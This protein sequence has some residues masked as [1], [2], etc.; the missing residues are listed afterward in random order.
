MRTKEFI[1][2]LD[3]D[4][5]V[6]AIKEAEAKSSGEIRVFVQRGEL[7]GDPVIAAQKKFH[8]LGM[9]ATKERNGVLIFVLPRARK[10]AVIGDE[11]VHQKC[12]PQF[13]QEKVD[14]MREHFKREEFTGA[15]VEAIEAAGQLLAE[16][17]PRQG[18]DRNE[19]SDEIVEG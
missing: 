3:H 14:R 5:I 12:G 4:R 1:S 19:L 10:F 11:G 15:L 8:E 16:H 7:E 9:G 17:F 18:G 13:W 2:Q 6:A